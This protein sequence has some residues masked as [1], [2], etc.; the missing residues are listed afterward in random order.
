MGIL[1]LIRFLFITHSVINQWGCTEV[2]QHIPVMVQCRDSMGDKE[3]LTAESTTPCS[4]HHY[5]DSGLKFHIL[6]MYFLE[7]MQRHKVRD[8][9][10][11]LD[12]E[13]VIKIVMP[14]PLAE[15]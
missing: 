13:S 5:T 2:F 15:V 6:Y 11:D 9:A 8:R 12:R 7:K 1:Q 3:T 14:D 10:L 4:H